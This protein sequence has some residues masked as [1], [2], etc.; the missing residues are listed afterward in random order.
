[1]HSSS[2]PNQTTSS[3]PALK[4]TSSSTL[5]E[6]VIRAKYFQD[7]QHIPRLVVGRVFFD[8][9]VGT[10]ASADPSG[11]FLANLGETGIGVG[12]RLVLD[13]LSARSEERRVGKE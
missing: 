11:S 4:L 8:S 13:A 9:K 5:H 12:Q 1:M 10:V 6:L 2:P 3:R 7:H